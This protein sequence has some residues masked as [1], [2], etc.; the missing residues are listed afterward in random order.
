[1]TDRTFVESPDHVHPTRMR[2]IG[3]TDLLAGLGQPDADIATLR[4]LVAERA[5][6]NPAVWDPA[7]RARAIAGTPAADAEL[8]A[9]DEVLRREVDFTAPS[10]G[11]S[12]LYGLHYLQWLRPLVIGYLLTGDDR[13][14]AAFG[15]H[16]DA[17]YAARDGVTGG[18]PGLDLV[19][20]SLGVWAR[21]TLLVPALEVFATARGLRDE[22]VASA[23]A[24]LLGGARWAAEEHDAFRP[25]NWQLVCAAELL[26]VAAFLAEAPEAGE[27]VATGQARV[28][29]HLDRDFYPDG[30]HHERSPGYHVLCVDALQ[31]AAVVSARHHE[32]ALAEHPAFAAV[33]DWLEA[34]TTPA[35]WVPAWQDSTTEWPAEVLERG[36]EI[37]GR[38]AGRKPHA[39]RLLTGSG[40]VV[41]RGSAPQNGY[42]ALNAGPYVDHELE[43]HSHL[44]VTDFVLSAWE[45]PLALDPGGP[46]SYDDPVYQTWYRDPRAHNMVTVDGH[47]CRT[48]RRAGVDAVLLSGPVQIVAA[49]HHGYPCLVSRR[50]VQ[51]DAEP[52]YWLVSDVVDG[53]HPATWS[54]FGPT[55][56]ERSGA[57][58]R[59]TGLPV[60]SVV[61]AGG[62]AVNATFDEGPGQV[63]EAGAATRRTLYALRL[64]SASG[65]FDV[66]LSASPA[67]AEPWRMTR[68][69][70]QWRLENG[71]LV[72]T[73]TDHRWE[74]WSVAGDPVATWEWRMPA[75]PRCEEHS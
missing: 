20:Y 69:S 60:L 23:F 5:A 59:S 25:G 46:A 42:L 74:R 52:G 28:L 39:S 10:Q 70:D 24:T 34:M 54:I 62:D 8:A 68:T 47:A 18:W 6:V 58:F 11:R 51:V 40:Y 66:A 13:Y 17:W 43:S 36:R 75:V 31:R 57:G 29:E 32:F 2:H 12:G 41:L 1:M 65:R 50:I 22:T 63:P 49:H 4:R 14:P 21:A 48:D 19:W 16:F 38:P 72:D 71:R 3:R 67:P 37:L 26:H 53:G 9:A 44:A 73:L 55:P 7:G 33:H 64:H 30:G 35:G 56:W 61:P 45:A 15:R 27:W